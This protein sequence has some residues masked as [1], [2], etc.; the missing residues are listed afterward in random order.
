[1]PSFTR[2]G[3][4]SAAAC[5]ALLFSTAAPA[6]PL[7]VDPAKSS[8]G[9][10]F[11]Q[12]G[13]P[14][15]A[16]FRKFAVLID[17]D[18]A[19]PESAKASVDIDTASFDIGD[20]EYNKEVRKKEWFDSDRFPRASFVSTAI[21]PAGAGRYE[22]SGKLTLKGRTADVRFPLAAKAEGG[23]QVFEGTLPISRLAFNIGEGEWKDTGVVADEVLVK[24]RVAAQ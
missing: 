24:F 1:M 20:P 18:A 9:A 6:A 10:V 15:E 5:A 7:K 17:L 14:V 4:A 2:A 11:K 8:V 16:K 13:V 22:V 21:K 19:K 3:L 12:I 23:G